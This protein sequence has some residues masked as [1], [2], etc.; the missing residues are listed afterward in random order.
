LTLRALQR[1][2][3]QG[4][5]LT[6]VLGGCVA[7]QIGGPTAPRDA[8]D[9]GLLSLPSGRSFSVYPHELAYTGSGS[10]RWPDGREYQGEFATGAPEGIGAMTWPNGDSYR[11]T[12]HDGAQHGHGELTRADGSRYVGGFVSGLRVGEGV[13]QTGEGLY[14]GNWLDD[15]PNGEGTFDAADGARYQGHWRDGFRQGF[16]SYTDTLRNRYEGEWQGD[17]PDGFGVMNNAN[18]SV[19][20]GEWRDGKREGYG[21]VTTE[22]GVVFE[23]T[24]LDGRRHGFGVAERPDGSRYEG[25]W[26]RGQREG[27]GR[28]SYRDGSAHQGI[29]KADEP[30]GPGIRTDRTGIA[31]IGNW[32]GDQLSAGR[33]RLPSGA[34]YAGELLVERNTAV[35]SGL[36]A[37]LEAQAG[38]PWAHFF[39]GTA[40]SDFNRPPPDLFTATGHFRIAAQAGI[41]D[42]QFR[43]ALL[44]MAK[45]PALGMEW[46]EKAA[47]AGQ[48]QANTLLGEYYLNGQWVQADLPMAVRHFRAASEAGDMTARNHLAWILATTRQPELRDGEASLALIRPLALLH[49]D[50][51]HFDTLAAAYAATGDYQQAA[52]AELRAI[53]DASQT[54]GEHSVEVSAMRERLDQ[55]RAGK[56]IKPETDLHD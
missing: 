56:P 45:S 10:Y 28:E 53:T 49:G 4:L 7:P 35:D 52:A 39:L 54:I 1:I 51:Q 30:L 19:Y 16:G 55:Y 44:I 5:I 13:E 42:A 46:L 25:A 32:D 20:E 38:D 8:A 48:A 37:W 36:L 11:G 41:P 43:L 18:G 17:V 2:A 29:W 50:W 33:I 26:A 21:T 22:A 12:W 31:I 14:R 6:G 9:A 47:A 27:S 24:W 15:L 40:Y 23:G 34:E 3:L